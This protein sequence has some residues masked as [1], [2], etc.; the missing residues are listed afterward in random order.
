MATHIAHGFI[1]VRF[2]ITHTLKHK[3]NT[4]MCVFACVHGVRFRVDVRACAVVIII[5]IVSFALRLSETFGLE[6]NSHM[7]HKY[8]IHMC[9]SCQWFRAHPQSTRCFP[10]ST[11]SSSSPSS[12]SSSSLFAQKQQ[13]LQ[14]QF[15]CILT[16]CCWLIR[17]YL[18]TNPHW[19]SRWGECPVHKIRAR[20]CLPTV[21]THR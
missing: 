1:L 18:R 10:A 2:E 3:Q 16:V 17:T 15:I 7:F 12:T 6:H 8:F 21:S 19:T 14:H 5:D 11:S 4:H 20:V 9:V 13:R